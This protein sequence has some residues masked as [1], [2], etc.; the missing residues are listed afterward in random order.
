MQGLDRSCIVPA[1]PTKGIAPG[2]CI[3]SV[4]VREAAQRLDLLPD[5]RALGAQPPQALLHTLPMSE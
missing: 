5:P 2:L 4:L 3:V 1:G